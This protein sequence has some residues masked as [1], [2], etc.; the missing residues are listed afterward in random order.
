MSRTTGQ[1][2]TLSGLFHLMTRLRTR[3]GIKHLQAHTFRRT[4]ALTALRN[5]MSIY[6]LCLSMRKRFTRTFGETGA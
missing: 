6:H 3:T 5:G 2:L 1:R 4:F